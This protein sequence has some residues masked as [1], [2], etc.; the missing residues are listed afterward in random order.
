MSPSDPNS[1]PDAASPGSPYPSPDPSSGTSPRPQSSEFE[2]P[3][4]A[5]FLEPTLPRRPVSKT[6]I[7]ASIAMLAF[8]VAL[9]VATWLTIRDEP[10]SN[11][12]PTQT[13]S[14]DQQQIT[15]VVNDFI[16]Y[17]NAGQTTKANEL[18][19]TGLAVME[20]P[21][22]TAPA[23]NPAV[24][25]KITGIA[26]QGDRATAIVT[27]SSPQTPEVNTQTMTMNFLNQGGW[28]VCSK[29]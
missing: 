10:V 5:E 25:E 1:T 8:I 18:A 12:L 26:V 7:A 24:V 16:E 3:D 4:P 22:D 9:G 14:S 27:I 19:C 13:S 15:N 6:L 20:N 17:T 29:P 21:A 11:G 23:S 28:K 2:T